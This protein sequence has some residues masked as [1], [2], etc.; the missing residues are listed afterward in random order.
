MILTALTRTLLVSGLALG[1]FEAWADTISLPQAVE[2]SLAADPRIKE[3]E[4][5]IESA[6]ALLQEAKANNGWRINANAFVGIAPEVKGGFYQNGATSGTTPRSDDSKIDGISDW[7]HLE[8]SLIKPLYTFG[9][10][11]R[12]GEAAQAN[13]DLKRGDLKQTR[14]DTVYDTKRAYYGY[15]TAR[16]VRVFL[17]DMQSRLAQTITTTAREL[18]EE[19]GQSKQSDLYAL[20]TAKGL[21]AKYVYQARAVEKIS[22]DGLR[23]ITGMGLNS[24]LKVTDERIEPVA[25]PK[26]ELAQLQA[27]A[28][29]ERPEMQ[30]LE[31]GLRSRRALVAAKK[32]DR[33]P[34]VYAGVVGAFNYA[35]NRDRLD[36]PHITDTF[37]GG[38]LTPVV[39]VKWDTT[40]GVAAAKVSQAQ[41]ELEALNH[42]KAFA[43]AGIPYEIS[44]AYANAQANFESQKEL[45]ESAAAARRWMVASL[46]DFS[47]GLEKGDKVAEALKSYTLANTEYLRTINDYNMN[48]AQLA[49]LSGELK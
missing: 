11:E 30:Q 49:R 45:A 2:M 15:L 33:M 47:A 4:Q 48:V 42:K 38:G 23:I 36:N 40:F 10:I 27:R 31:A 32:A 21:I 14:A 20:Q 18:K 7:T 13:I 24:D 3:R 19:S 41:A 8:F 34:D 22:L 37:N 29:V 26:T 35:S 5:L 28:L 12:Y 43:L 17:E 6:R 16:D 1:T 46:A 44:E 39:G 25:F 9:K